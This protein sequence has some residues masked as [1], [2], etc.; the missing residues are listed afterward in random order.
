MKSGNFWSASWRLW[1]ALGALLIAFFFVPGAWKDAY[2]AKLAS[3]GLSPKDSSSNS[4]VDHLQ[5]WSDRQDLLYQ[6]CESWQSVAKDYYRQEGQQRLGQFSIESV[7][8]ALGDA[9]RA[10]VTFRPPFTTSTTLWITA[11]SDIQKGA[12]VVKGDVLVGVIDY[13]GSN[14]S[15]VRLVTDPN[16]QIAVRVLRP[17]S[18]LAPLYQDLRMWIDYLAAMN[19][20][21]QQASLVKQLEQV[22][23]EF[24]KE[25]LDSRPLA[26]GLVRGSGQL[27]NRRYNLLEG[28]GFNYTWVD[29]YL[30]TKDP[31][32][33]LVQEG[34]EL[35]SSGLDGIFP[36]GL[37]VARVVKVQ[38][39][40][41]AQSIYRLQALPMISNFDDLSLVWV[42]PPF[43]K[44]DE[45]KP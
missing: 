8:T 9:V 23:A 25:P 21:A 43:S 37:R 31:R 24:K 28:S 6:R 34:D 15:R 17:Q 11:K 35:V 40:D 26:K 4:G 7:Q 32:A 36:Q 1:V 10:Q 33:K 3:L 5:A 19:L 45:E 42:L 30:E 39:E 12:A 20:Q 29:S 41:P 27:W 44:I 22:C 16:V 14:A 18:I 38:P 13:V 2:G